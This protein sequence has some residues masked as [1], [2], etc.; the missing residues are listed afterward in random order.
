M[1]AIFRALFR[2]V[3]IVAGYAAACLALS[4]FIHLLVLGGLAPELPETRD[5]LAVTSV[6]TVPALAAWA[7]YHLFV[8]ATV[9]VAAAEFGAARDWHVHA[10]GGAGATLAAVSF[11]A[12][13]PGAIFADTG[14]VAVLTAAGLVGGW[15]YWFVAGRRS[16]VWRSPV[17]GSTSLGS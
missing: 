2:L 15:V 14:L 5:L 16:G 8:P 9:L 17:S 7:G 13:R 12:A 6:L 11:A 3:A 10:I 1:T 4:G